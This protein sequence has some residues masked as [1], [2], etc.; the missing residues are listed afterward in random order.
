MEGADSSHHVAVTLDHADG[1]S[2]TDGNYRLTPEEN[3]E[4]LKIADILLKVAKE[5]GVDINQFS[6]VAEAK[7][8]DKNP[9]EISREELAAVI[10]GHALTRGTP[11]SQFVTKVESTMPTAGQGFGLAQEPR[12]MQL[13]VELARQVFGDTYPALST[14]DTTT[15]DSLKLLNKAADRGPGPVR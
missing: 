8:F 9:A 12:S 5:K 4:A 14:A 10:M 13:A 3:R 6:D 7:A 1:R 2:I 15:R 11:P